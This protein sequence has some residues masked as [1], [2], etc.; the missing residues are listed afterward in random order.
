MSVHLIIIFSGSKSTIGKLKA[1][2]S[3]DDLQREKWQSFRKEKGK[4]N[5]SMPFKCKSSTPGS[6]HDIVKIQCRV[7]R[8]EVVQRS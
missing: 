6:N 8:L 3:R 5:R 4:K 1:D 7:Y 2:H